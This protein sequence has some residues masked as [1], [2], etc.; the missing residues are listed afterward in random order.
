MGVTLWTE[1][2]MFQKK[3]PRGG[4]AP[5]GPAASALIQGPVSTRGDAG[6]HLGI[7]TKTRSS[8]VFPRVVDKEQAEVERLVQTVL[9]DLAQTAK[10]HGNAAVVS[11]QISVA[12]HAGV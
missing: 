8:F 3:S 12:T 1:E 9:G 7:V 5:G 4:A 6:R 10:E 11:V 2:G